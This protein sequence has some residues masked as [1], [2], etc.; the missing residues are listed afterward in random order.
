MKTDGFDSD[1]DARNLLQTPY[2]KMPSHD[3]IRLAGITPSSILP[4][5]MCAQPPSEQSQTS[6]VLVPPLSQ[7]IVNWQNKIK[8][9][10]L[11]FRPYEE[12]VNVRPELPPDNG[13]FFHL[14]NC[15]IKIIRNTLEDN[16]FRDVKM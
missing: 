3:Q 2:F 6:E 16:G 1:A 9:N 5:S 15:D 14:S 8:K 11:V 13:Y 7:K 4:L 12:P 10:W